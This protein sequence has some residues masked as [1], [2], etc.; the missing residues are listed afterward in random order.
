MLIEYKRFFWW[1]KPSL[2]YAEEIE[3]GKEIA[4]RGMGPFLDDFLEATQPPIYRNRQ[5][6]TKWQAAKNC[7][8]PLILIT[9]TIMRGKGGELLAVISIGLF[10]C[11]IIL[12]ISN[13]RL[14]SWLKHLVAQYAAYLRKDNHPLSLEFVPRKDQ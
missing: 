6:F 13:I 10:L 12:V 8:L 2:S 5:T 3:F 11:I 9:L 4:E 14:N 7:A 1:A